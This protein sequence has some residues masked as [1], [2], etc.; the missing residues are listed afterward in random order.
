[1][2]IIHSKPKIK[3]HVRTAQDEL[4]MAHDI[5]NAFF[6]AGNKNTSLERS[7]ELIL[8]GE[9]W[10][11]TIAREVLKSLMAGL[12][13]NL[14]MGPTMRDVSGRARQAASEYGTDRTIFVTMYAIGFLVLLAPDAIKALGF[15][16]WKDLPGTSEHYCRFCIV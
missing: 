7:I 1:M 13:T 11:E 10:T 12:K 4:I 9:G 15:R 16:K 3:A 14:A 2:G 5:T 6:E 8:M